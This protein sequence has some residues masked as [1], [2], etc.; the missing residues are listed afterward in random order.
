VTSTINGFL[1]GRDPP[2]CATWIAALGHSADAFGAP[3]PDP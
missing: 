1:D 3:P 2:A